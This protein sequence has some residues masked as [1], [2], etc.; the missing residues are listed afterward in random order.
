MMHIE[1]II[2]TYKTIK[3]NIRREKVKGA[4]YREKRH[5]SNSKVEGPQTYDPPVISNA[6]MYVL[7]IFLRKY[8]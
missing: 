8:T 1:G 4:V 6:T 2:D 7:I 5:N 3:Y